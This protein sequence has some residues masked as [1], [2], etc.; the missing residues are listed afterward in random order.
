MAGKFAW[1]GDEGN[2][3]DRKDKEDTSPLYPAEPP[4]KPAPDSEELAIRWL[5]YE[6][7]PLSE[8]EEP[9]PESSG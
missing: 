5:C 8:P 6:E 7:Y 3:M 4:K 9:D 1:R 2:P